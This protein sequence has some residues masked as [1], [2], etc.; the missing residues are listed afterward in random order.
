[1][2][3]SGRFFGVNK[4]KVTSFRPPPKVVDLLSMAKRVFRPVFAWFWR[5]DWDAGAAFVN[6]RRDHPGYSIASYIA[7]TFAGG[8]SARMLWTC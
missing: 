2:R 8:T 5:R 1:M 3:R 6:R 7:T 4:A